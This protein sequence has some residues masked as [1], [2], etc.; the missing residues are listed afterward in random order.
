M[1]RLTS[2]TLT[3]TPMLAL[4][5]AHG[6][7]RPRSVHD[8][9][10]LLYHDL[11]KA[12]LSSSSPRR[13]FA[14]KLSSWKPQAL[15]SPPFLSP[16]CKIFFCDSCHS[17]CRVQ[18]HGA[19]SRVRTPSQLLSSLQEEALERLYSSNFGLSLPLSRRSVFSGCLSREIILSLNLFEKAYKFSS[20]IV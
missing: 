18:A 8:M 4:L 5:I 19:R 17:L 2:S 15:S 13:L 14:S 10:G 11:R 3:T 1:T 16:S 12:H 20:I 7:P 9:C 6:A